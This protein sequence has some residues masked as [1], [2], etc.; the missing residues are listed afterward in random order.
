MGAQKVS[1]SYDALDR[2]VLPTVYQGVAVRMDGTQRVV[3]VSAYPIFRVEDDQVRKLGRLIVGRSDANVWLHGAAVG[4][5]APDLVPELPVLALKAE[6]PP[7]PHSGRDSLRSDREPA[8]SVRDKEA[9]RG[10]VVLTELR[11]GRPDKAEKAPQLVEI[12]GP[13]QWHIEEV[14]EDR[15]NS[16]IHVLGEQEKRPIGGVATAN[17]GEQQPRLRVAGLP[18]RLQL[19]QVAEPPLHRATA[20]RP[21]AGMCRGLFVSRCR[22]IEHVRDRIKAGSPGA[23]ARFHLAMLNEVE[24]I[25]PDLQADLLG[26]LPL[27]SRRQSWGRSCLCED[28]S[29]SHRTQNLRPGRAQSSLS[30][31]ALD[32]LS[33]QSIPLVRVGWRGDVVSIIGGASFAYDRER[34]EWQR[35]MRDD[36]RRRV[37]ISRSLIA[38]KLAASIVT[39]RD[40]VEPSSRRHSA[41]RHATSAIDQLHGNS[42]GS[43]DEVRIIEARCAASYFAAWRGAPINWR[44]RSKH[45][46]PNSWTSVQV[47]GSLR[48]SLTSG[49]RHATHPVNAMLNYAYAILEGE[50]HI[51]ALSEGYDPRRGVMHHDRTDALAFVYDLMEPHRPR[52]DRAVLHFVD[53]NTFSGADFVLRSDGVCRVAP[54]MARALCA[55]AWT[56]INTGHTVLAVARAEYPL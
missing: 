54:Q 33:S 12:V 32:W 10:Q 47:R 31:D 11:D 15:R 45:P 3:E 13:G 20:P 56:A 42:I 6:L 7:R 17:S 53:S 51:S 40:A 39:L 8:G 5:L 21:G 55:T 38:R 37:E 48:T 29:G 25:A 24:R 18:E 26:Q 34:L 43:V 16:E 23:Q 1:G 4:S 36:E 9:V 46:I 28:A 22:P 14:A 19:H 41:E 27:E 49:N 44:S 50:T 30:F 52:V 35:A 2:I